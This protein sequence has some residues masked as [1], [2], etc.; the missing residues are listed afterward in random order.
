[1]SER[2]L[3]LMRNSPQWVEPVEFRCPVY[4]RRL[5]GKFYTD[6]PGE[7]PDAVLEFAC[8]DC[9]KAARPAPVR[10]LHHFDLTGQHLRTD[11]Q[12]VVPRMPRS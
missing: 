5:F 7:H 8:D 11:S 2:I 10:V 1:M 3:E 4:P 6:V 9:R 12:L